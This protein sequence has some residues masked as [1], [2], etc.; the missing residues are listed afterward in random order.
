MQPNQMNATKNSHWLRSEQLG[1]VNQSRLSVN[2]FVPEIWILEN[3]SSNS[4][5]K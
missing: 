2:V 3:D 1:A 5:L 4:L